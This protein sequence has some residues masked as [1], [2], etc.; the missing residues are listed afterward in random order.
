[1]L[2]TCPSCR[3]SKEVELKGIP[4]T[5][6]T[7]PKCGKRFKLPGIGQVAEE[8]VVTANCP[9][10]AAPLPP[11]A[12]L[13]SCPSCGLIFAKYMRRQKQLREQACGS[14]PKS[15]DVSHET[16]DRDRKD[17]SLRI[18][19]KYLLPAI[20]LSAVAALYYYPSLPRRV[21]VY[22][23]S[24]LET[25]VR[26]P[27]WV[28]VIGSLNG[29]TH[30]DSIAELAD[31]TFIL[32]GK[33]S[34]REGHAEKEADFKNMSLLV[35]M[36]A[37]GRIIWSRNY[38]FGEY[39][40]IFNMCATDDGGFAVAFTAGE[41]GKIA[42]FDEKGNIVW[43]TTFPLGKP[44][45]LCKTHDNGIAFSGTHH[46]G[47]GHFYLWAGKLNSSGELVWNRSLGEA[48]SSNIVHLEGEGFLVTA[49]TPHLGRF[50]ISFGGFYDTL[51]IKLDSY[52]TLEWYKKIQNFAEKSTA[53][54]LPDGGFIVA[55]SINNNYRLTDRPTSP[56][57]MAYLMRFDAKGDVIWSKTYG[58]EGH[59]SFSG[60][61]ISP[62]GGFYVTGYR[63]GYTEEKPQAITLLH[64]D[65][66][67][68]IKWQ[69]AFIERKSGIGPEAILLSGSD[70]LLFGSTGAYGDY[71]KTVVMK[72]TSDGGTSTAEKN[73]IQ[74]DLDYE[75]SNLMVEESSEH[76]IDNVSFTGNA[77]K[78]ESL[79]SREVVLYSRELVPTA[80]RV[81]L[82]VYSAPAAKVCELYEVRLQ[83]VGMVPL[84]VEKIFAEGLDRGSFK[85][86]WTPKVIEP[87]AVCSAML[88]CSG[89][90]NSANLVVFSNDPEQPILTKRI[91]YRPVKDGDD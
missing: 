24:M 40:N 69:K 43:I 91:G 16:Q 41:D 14:I 83:N 11:D 25:R 85:L 54:G 64:L 90:R 53:W 10:C 79:K 7:C 30:T 12:S 82:Y 28:R 8:P 4:P 39:A 73:P 74:A 48:Y 81:A 89:V 46:D 66:M 80:P 21:S 57:T 86:E 29:A 26:H 72:L 18:S 60:L 20:L 52:G 44:D 22:L 71:W 78:P 32:A 38:A 34:D 13:E 2:I 47:L 77:M 6:A 68:G 67:G 31:G 61:Q 33:C 9:G 1:M 19:V 65:D 5:S 75:P 62:S 15:G 76:R 58:G 37:D 35:R 63:C 42:R 70:L 27:Y 17:N 87:G 45:S 84:S 49:R 50:R 56:F 55:G 51:L 23:S 36:G 88:R 3:F 59:N